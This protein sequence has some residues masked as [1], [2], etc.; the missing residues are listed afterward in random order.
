MRAA[1]EAG[2][3]CKE[4]EAVGDLADVF[5]C[6]ARRSDGA[7]AAILP[8]VDVFLRVKCNNAFSGCTGS[9][10]DTY[11][12]FQVAAKQAIGI[13]FSEVVFGEG[14]E[15]SEIVNGFDIV[16]CDTLFFHFLAVVRDIFPNVADLPEKLF[17]LDGSHGLARGP[18]DL[19]L[20]VTFHICFLSFITADEI[21]CRL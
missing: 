14:R 21:H 20:I 10:M 11:T 1:V 5:I 4:A 19:F 3:A 18:F 7:S 16:R 6:S 8:Q 12:F 17:V 9:G 15:L 13:G 2:A